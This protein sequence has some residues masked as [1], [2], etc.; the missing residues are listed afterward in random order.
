MAIMVERKK[1]VEKCH[2]IGCQR[3]KI[4][5][6]KNFAKSENWNTKLCCNPSLVNWSNALQKVPKRHKFHHQIW[7]FKKWVSWAKPTLVFLI[8]FPMCG[9]PVTCHSII[10]HQ[11][12]S[13]F[14]MSTKKCYSGCSCYHKSCENVLY[15][16][17]APW[18]ER[19]TTHYCI[20]M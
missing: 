14:F 2:M 15:T 4:F 10:T 7:W 11:I 19:Q 3:V 12:P 20:S 17:F 6:E 18:I 8:F 13:D 5:R 16:I 1:G 9:K